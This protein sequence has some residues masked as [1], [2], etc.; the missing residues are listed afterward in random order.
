MLPDRVSNPRPLTYE[1][2]A[3]PIALRGPALQG[4]GQLNIVQENLTEKLRIKRN[5]IFQGQIPVQSQLDILQ[6][7]V[8]IKQRKVSHKER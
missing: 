3:L 7:K 6:G 5:K 2:G 4:Q 8:T 1:S